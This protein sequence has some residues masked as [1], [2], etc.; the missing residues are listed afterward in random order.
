MCISKPTAISNMA[1]FLQTM[2]RCEIIAQEVFKAVTVADDTFR[3]RSSQMPKCHK[4][5]KKI[6]LMH[7]NRVNMGKMGWTQWKE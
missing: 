4:N 2:Q 7:T 1:V 5:H 6:A 3:F